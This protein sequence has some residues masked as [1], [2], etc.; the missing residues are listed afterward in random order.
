MPAV[1]V[2]PALYGYD[3][4]EHCPL[5]IIYLNAESGCPPL[6]PILKYPTPLAQSTKN[7]SD[8]S[9]NSPDEIAQTDSALAVVANAQQEPHCP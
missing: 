9:S 3:D 6:H 8:K 1:F 4:S 7:S 5:L 2:T